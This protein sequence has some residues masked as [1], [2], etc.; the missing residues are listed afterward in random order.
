MHRLH[1]FPHAPEPGSLHSIFQRLVSMCNFV[2]IPP[3]HTLYFWELVQLPTVPFHDLLQHHGT[4]I[5][6]S[7]TRSPDIWQHYRCFGVWMGDLESVRPGGCMSVILSPSPHIRISIF[8]MLCIQVWRYYQ[9]YPND[10]LSYKVLV[11]PCCMFHPKVADAICVLF[12][13]LN[14]RRLLGLDA[15]VRPFRPVSTAYLAFIIAQG[16]GGP[17]P[18]PCWSHHLVLRRRVGSSR[19]FAVV[20]HSLSFSQEFRRHVYFS[21]TPSVVSL[22]VSCCRGAH[23]HPGSMLLGLFV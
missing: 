3:L 13:S 17:P 23:A 14:D 1:I 15:L 21:Q 22:R 18:S 2:S 16:T 19:T 6:T 5:A 9:R 4:T 10:N 12:M 7:V 11:R 20:H 8:G